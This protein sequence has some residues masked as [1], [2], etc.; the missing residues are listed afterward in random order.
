MMNSLVIKL[1]LK[2][3]YFVLISMIRFLATA[4]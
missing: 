3:K 1:I 4:E 2:S